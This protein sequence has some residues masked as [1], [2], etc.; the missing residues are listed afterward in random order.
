MDKKIVIL[1]SFAEAE[2]ADK[3]YYRSLSPKERLAILLELNR[4]WPIRDDA[5]TSERLARVYRIAKLA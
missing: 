5:E 1:D 4:R 3:E 2:R